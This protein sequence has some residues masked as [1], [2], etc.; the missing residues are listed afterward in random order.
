MSYQSWQSQSTSP[1]ERM[2][3][4]R[5]VGGAAAV[6][7]V[8]SGFGMIVTY[9]STGVVDITWLENPG[10][11]LGIRGYCFDGTTQS[12][13]KGFTVVAGD[14]PTAAP[15]TIR[16]NITNNSDTL[17]DLSASQRLSI[18]FAWSATS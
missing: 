7:K 14:P 11:F 10:K 4:I 16:L 12:G 17:T 3:S 18:T 15:Y 1:D 5:F 2:H 9:I 6:T 8:A 13:L